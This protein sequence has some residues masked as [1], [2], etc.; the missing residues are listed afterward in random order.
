MFLTSSMKFL[1]KQI[2]NL[3]LTK[4]LPELARNMMMEGE[5]NLENQMHFSA[6]SSKTFILNV[7]FFRLVI[8]FFKDLFH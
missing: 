5:S 4:N 6:H 3:R 2:F 8:F 7:D 1:Y